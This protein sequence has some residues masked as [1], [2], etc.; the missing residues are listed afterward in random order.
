MA[1]MYATDAAYGFEPYGNVLRQTWYGIVTANAV[2]M[3]IGDLVEAVGEAVTTPKHGWIQKVITEETG[4]AGDI[5]GVVT[6]LCDSN[7]DPV[8]RIA[9]ST[10]GNSTIAGYALVADHPD[11]VFHAQQDGDTTSIYTADIGLMA[12][13]ISTS[14]PAANNN[15]LSTMEI[16]SS[17]IAGTATLALHIIG[18][19]PEDT[20]GAASTAGNYARL[21]C[22]INSHYH[23]RAH[24]GA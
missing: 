17:T 14:T 3:C 20:I 6:A 21:L 8:Y 16:D 1:D 4:S 2:Q 5:V 13:A 18:V 23:G 15:Y 12:D 7:G 19:H 11:Q 9:A 22:T 10:T 24:T